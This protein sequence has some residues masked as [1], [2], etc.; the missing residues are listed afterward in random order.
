MIIA[1]ERWQRHDGREDL[2][3]LFDD[4]I[5]ALAASATDLRD[6]VL[7]AAAAGTRPTKPEAVAAKRKP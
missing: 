2:L 6:T 1:V 5:A 3:R 4:A 7:T